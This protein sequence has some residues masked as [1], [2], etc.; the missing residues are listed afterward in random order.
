MRSKFK[1]IFTLV[2]AFLVQFSFAQERTITGVVTENGMPLPGATVVIKGTKTGTQADFDGKYTIKAKQ[3]DVLEF[4][5]V[6]MK[7]KTAT[8]GASNTVNVAMESDSTLETIEIVAEGYRTVAKPKSVSASQTIGS[9]TLENRPN[10]NILNT[11]QGQLAGVNIASGSGQPGAR[12]SVTIRGVGTIGANT[13]PLYVID[14]FPSTVDNYRSM[15]P[16]DFDTVT[17]LKDAS[18][19][20]Q[21]GNRGSNGV[22][23]INTKRAKYGDAKT[24][25]R[26]TSNFGLTEL[27][28]ARYTRATGSQM[29][30]LQRQLGVGY[31]GTLTEAQIQAQGLRSINTDWVDFF[32]RRGTSV[33][34]NLA[35]ENSSKNISS[36]T[37]LSYAKQDGI[38]E[39]T[40]LQRFTLRNNLNGKSSNE[41]FTYMVNT[42]LGFSKNQLPGNLGD[43]AVNRN[44]VLGAYMALPFL[45]PARY[46]GSVWALNE[47]NTTPGLSATPY[48]LMDRQLT[49]GNEDQETKI[50]LNTEFT[51]KL[52]K[53][54]TLRSRING[55]YLNARYNEFES[56]DSFNALLF[57]STAGVPSFNGGNFNGYELIQQR[58]EFY[59]NNLFQV[60]YSKSIKKHNFDVFANMEYNHSALNTNN[61]DQRGLNPLTWVPNTGAGWAVDVGTNDFF[62]P[63]IS[64][65]RIRRDLISYFGIL[66]YDFDSKFGLS[67]SFRRDGSSVF[68]EGFK[69]TNTWSVGGRWNID[70]MGFMQNAKSI[71]MLKLRGSYGLTANERL[72]AGTAFAGIIPG[73]FQDSFTNFNNAY[74]GQVGLNYSKGAFDLTW[75][76]TFNTN[77]GLDFAM[78]NNRLKGSIDAYNRKTEK[79]FFAQPVSAAVG[80]P[81]VVQNSTIDVNNQ[82]LELALA[83]DLIKKDDL[84]LT[85]RA[86]GSY[87]KNEVS[88]ISNAAGFIRDGS[89][90]YE[91]GRPLR[92]YWLVPYAGVNP[93]TGNLHFVAANGTLT[94]T[95]TDADRRLTGL[96]NIPTYQGGFGLDFSYKGFY[97]N[98]LFSFVTDVHR[99]DFDQADL[100]SAA[101]IGQFV[102][103]S[104]LTNAWS[105]TNT[106]SNV[107][108]LTATNAGFANSDRWIRDASYLRMRNLQV[109]YRFNK[110]QLKNLFITDLGFT[111]QAENLFTLTK[112]DG[113]DA[114][115]NRTGDQRQYPTP[116]I[117]TFGIDLKF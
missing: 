7:T 6:G 2:L 50:D 64:A 58:R 13:D 43:G 91:N 81:S 11:L 56:P 22:I 83:Y 52:F 99:F 72:I 89:L 54:L 49:W 60:H 96:N 5:Y 78:F 40:G 20:A 110:K 87:N 97:L 26:Y 16:N 62:V 84:K 61:L 10:A 112:W 38:L 63:R 86:N 68:N 69:W 37:S 42:A 31:G 100:Y 21:Y 116:R 8:V 57:S 82:G 18:A 101:N 3:G 107:P 92:E 27:Q 85:I 109:G 114:E 66:D 47:F 105:P 74:N 41:K 29:L 76:A 108:S 14:G 51:Y 53:D 34:H 73:L 111:L 35:I 80:Q 106:T 77:I 79:I 103:H 65:S 30:D 39:N 4:S 67:G 44:Y 117:Y 70:K 17:V 94:E 71:N 12:P 36:F 46:Q 19:I 59:F 33:D 23:V 32:F 15:N 95:P 104:D 48:M 93:A 45:S 25:F 28:N 115:S 90:S 98:T 55:T 88:G 24:T 113:F 102:V 9:E 75:E 1:W